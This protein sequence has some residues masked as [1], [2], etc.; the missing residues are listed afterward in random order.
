[1]VMNPVDSFVTGLAAAHTREDVNFMTFPFQTCSQFGDVN[2]DA[3]NLDRMEGFPG[4][5]GYSHVGPSGCR[6]TTSSTL[7]SNQH[8]C[9]EQKTMYHPTQKAY[10]ERSIEARIVESLTNSDY[11]GKEHPDRN[12]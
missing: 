1:M 10:G 12:P 9:E 11:E 5:Y 2:G 6:T 8:E 7:H 3:A 4:E